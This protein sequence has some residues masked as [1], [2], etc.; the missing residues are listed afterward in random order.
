MGRDTAMAERH[1]SL[2]KRAQTALAV[3]LIAA[4]A[5]ADAQE[6]DGNAGRDAYLA[7]QAWLH[8]AEV[9]ANL[10]VTYEICGWGTI[11][12]RPIV[13]AEVMAADPHVSTWDTVAARYEAAQR[14]RRRLEAALTAHGHHEP[15]RRHVG[16][17][18][19]EGC[20]PELRERIEALTG[21]TD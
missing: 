11:D 1:G 16:L 7:R 13:L 4:S 14:E 2:R 9:L 18:P 21:V 3:A 6:A 8:R 17:Y 10:A 5:P 20:R 15:Y 19:T 12:L